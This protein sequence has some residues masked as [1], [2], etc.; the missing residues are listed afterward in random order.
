MSSE[1]AGGA[2]EE[3][4]S[5]QSEASVRPRAGCTF[6]PDLSAS[7]CQPMFSSPAP[8]H[9]CYSH[10]VGAALILF[11]QYLRVCGNAQVKIDQ[12]VTPLHDS[13]CHISDGSTRVVGCSVGKDNSFE[14][15]LIHAPA[16]AVFLQMLHQE[17][18]SPHSQTGFHTGSNLK[19]L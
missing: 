10:P 13:S 4:E 18:V 14:L 2:D 3:Q 1:A 5:W 11:R 6:C 15:C 16:A 8:R 19:R 17:A 12:K 7:G 9:P